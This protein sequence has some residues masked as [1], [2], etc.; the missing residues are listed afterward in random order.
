MEIGTQKILSPFLN[1]EICNGYTCHGRDNFE[2]ST[3]DINP[4]MYYEG[5]TINPTLKSLIF[6]V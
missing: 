1:T 5:L 6:H 4:Q 3:T 2:K